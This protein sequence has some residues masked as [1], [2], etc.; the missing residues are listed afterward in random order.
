MELVEEDPDSLDGI[1]FP[2]SPTSS[3]RED[4]ES[5]E[6]SNEQLQILKV[7]DRSFSRWRAALETLSK[8]PL[9]EIYTE[10]GLDPRLKLDLSQSFDS[11]SAIDLVSNDKTLKAALSGRHHFWRDHNPLESAFIRSGFKST[12]IRQ[13]TSIMEIS[14]QCE[15]GTSFSVR[16]PSPVIVVC[17]LAEKHTRDGEDGGLDQQWHE[18]FRY[19]IRLLFASL[20]L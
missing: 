18:I 12:A 10:K 5:P 19:P 2:M 16:I 1:Q 20:D 11:R 13:S 15:L 17:S 7:L 14:F 3:F 8:E 9:Y 6:I 4:V